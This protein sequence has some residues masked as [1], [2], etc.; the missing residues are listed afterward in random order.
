M[1][2]D[3]CDMN[4][5]VNPDKNVKPDLNENTNVNTDLNLDVSMDVNTDV[6]TDINTDVN[7]NTNTD[8]QN[9]DCE[10]V[11]PRASNLQRPQQVAAVAGSS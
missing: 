3:T 9:S 1:E 5:V 11:V 2:N 6:K 10:E 4:K 8:Q 7:M